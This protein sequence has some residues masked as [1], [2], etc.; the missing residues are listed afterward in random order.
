MSTSFHILKAEDR[1]MASSG[2][3]H[4]GTG[5]LRSVPTIASFQKER[6]PA[7]LHIGLPAVVS[8]IHS[9]SLIKVL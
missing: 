4:T 5:N 7:Y 3:G 9:T 1:A 2:G 8:F 6:S